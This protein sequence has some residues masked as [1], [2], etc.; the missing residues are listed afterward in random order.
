LI[1]M[2]APLAIAQATKFFKKTPKSH[3]T[4]MDLIQVAMEG[5]ASGVDKYVCPYRNKSYRQV[6]I[7]RIKGNLIEAYSETMIHFYPS[8]KRKL[9]NANKAMRE[10][11]VEQQ[12]D[13]KGLAK[14]IN[15][16][17]QAAPVHHHAGR[18]RGARG[19]RLDCLGRLPALEPRRRARRRHHRAVRG[20]RR[21][22]AR[23]PVRA[24]RGALRA[25]GR[26]RA[27]LHP[28]A[29][30]AAA[31]G[32]R[33]PGMIDAKKLWAQVQEN[34][35]KLEGCTGPHDF[36]VELEPRRSLLKRW[37][38]TRCGGSCDSTAKYWYE[39]GL[40]DGRS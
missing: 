29:E 16:T 38:C 19:R 32:R 13:F 21:A 4:R 24:R 35:R 40:K 18:D 9:Y 23:S 33:D 34:I 3:M 39:R 1:E 15:D 26:D 8:D 12:V 22:A 6:L 27:A 25:D 31:E 5:L 7:G 10:F 2:N 36:S 14:R 20:R 17:G 37:Q 28:G 11:S 30:G